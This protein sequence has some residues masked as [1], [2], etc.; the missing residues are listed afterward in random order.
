M[1][2]PERG[3]QCGIKVG[4]VTV[5]YAKG[6]TLSGEKG[7]IDITSLD[8][9]CWKEIMGGIKSASLSLPALFVGDDSGQTALYTAWDDDTSVSVTLFTALGYG[10]SFSAKVM[11]FEF[12][13]E[14]EDAVQFSITV[15]STGAITKTTGLS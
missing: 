2:S 13:A 14:L 9:N 6:G 12:V 5:G 1:G 15:N 11:N 4:G 10:F 3:C 7:E 8:S